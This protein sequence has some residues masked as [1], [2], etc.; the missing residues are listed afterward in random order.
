MIR[1]PGKDGVAF[2][3]RGD[4]DLREDPDSR[5]LLARALDV[6]AQWA[7]ARQ[8]HG[9]DLVRVEGPGNAGEF[10]ALWTTIPGLPLAIFT[11]DCLGV[12]LKSDEA[13]GVAHAGWRGADAGVVPALREAMTRA[14]HEPRFA[15]NQSGG[16]Q[17]PGRASVVDVRGVVV[18]EPAPAA[19]LVLLIREPMAGAYGGREA[20]VAALDARGVQTA[21]YLPAI[22]LQP[23]MQ[24]RYGF[25]AGL[26]PVAEEM[27]GRTLALPFHARL[28]ED[29]QE[30]V[31]SALR[32]ALAA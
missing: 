29:D 19:V 31:A 23:Y 8:V 10:D 13:V 17:G 1:P 12:V 18:L 24:E 6:P 26:C 3:E 32:E 30:H 22:H 4:G 7:W 25:R 15:G 14:G 28:D 9:A 16:E 2:S 21:R 11:A 5:E 27:S 20:V